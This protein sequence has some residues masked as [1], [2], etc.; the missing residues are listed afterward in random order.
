MTLCCTLYF[1]LT[2]YDVTQ[3]ILWILQNSTL[4]EP[5]PP[6]EIFAPILDLLQQVIDV[7]VRG[8]ESSKIRLC[9]AFIG[10]GPEFAHR[11]LSALDI[12]NLTDSFCHLAAGTQVMV[13]HLFGRLLTF[14]DDSVISSAAK[15]IRWLDFSPHIPDSFDKKVQKTFLTVPQLVLDR[16]LLAPITCRCSSLLCLRWSS[17]AC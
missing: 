15:Q 5:K 11:F 14:P 4:V 3:R 6:V 16:H 9:C 12:V 1:E 2:D 13:L 17:G 7:G 10:M 8:A